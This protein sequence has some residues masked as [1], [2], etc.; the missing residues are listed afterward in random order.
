MTSIPATFTCRDC[1]RLNRMIDP[2]GRQFDEFRCCF[3]GNSG[4]GV[5]PGR[6]FTE[7]NSK[8]LLSAADGF[9]PDGVL[10]GLTLDPATILDNA[11]ST[12]TVQ[13]DG[14]AADGGAIV[15][16]TSGTTGKAT[17][18]ANVTVRAGATSATF[19]VTAHEA[20]TS[21]ISAVYRGVT[22][23]ATVTVSAS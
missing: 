9:M 1:G 23:T 16:L 3:C 2:V 7:N 22:K 17:V 18:P 11:T 12:A 14:P 5:M 6:G 19:T 13:L 10:S 8:S 4:P 15:T 20:G 21:L